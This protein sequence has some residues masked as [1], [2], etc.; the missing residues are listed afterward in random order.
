MTESMF[1]L[2]TTF[3]WALQGPIS[4]SSKTETTC[5]LLQLSESGQIDKQ[6][7]ALWELES[8]G[9]MGEETEILEHKEALECLEETSTYKDR[10]YQVELPW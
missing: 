2:E 5:K 10:C 4:I 7:D 8:L 9:I 3:E 1:A 6:L